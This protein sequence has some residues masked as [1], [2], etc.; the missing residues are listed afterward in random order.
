M[1]MLTA[2]D[3]VGFDFFNVQDALD[4]ASS[5]FLCFFFWLGV[6]PISRFSVAVLSLPVS[7]RVTHWKPR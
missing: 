7:S 2:A 6:C 1:S 3:E 5:V 4:R